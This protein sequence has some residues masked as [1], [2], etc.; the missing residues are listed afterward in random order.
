MIPRLVHALRELGPRSLSQ[1]G[2][3]NLALR[4]G[5]YRRRLPIQSW[6]QVE[7]S[8]R[9]CHDVP[10][11]PEGYTAYRVNRQS[12]SVFKLTPSDHPLLQAV[13]KA[14]EEE[15]KGILDGHFRLFGVPGIH[16]G[17]P[18]NWYAYAPLA[19]IEAGETVQM[20]DH[21][22]TYRLEQL[23]H[24]V[25]LLWEP[26]RFGWVYPLT[27][28]Y[29]LSGDHRYVEGFW[30]LYTSWLES[31]P[32]QAGL[33]WFSA[34]E[35]A[36]RL[37]AL[38]FAAYTFSDVMED[39]PQR[40]MDLLRGIVVH[41]ER[42]PVSLAYARA[43]DNNHLLVES[44]ALFLVGL[45]FPEFAKAS[46]WKR[47]GRSLFLAGMDRQVFDD[48]GYVQ[49]STNY[50]RL[51]LQLGILVAKE[52]SILG[53]PLNSSALKALADMATCLSALVDEE[54]GQTPNFGPNDGAMLLPLSNCDFEDYRPTLQA[55]SYLLEG[56][57]RYPSGQW[58]DLSLWLKLVTG[59]KGSVTTARQDPMTSQFPE[60][61][62]Y[63]TQGKR[64]K[65]M[66][67]VV[68]FRNRPGHS[69][70][71]HLD[72]WYRGVNL[73]RDP[74]SYL[75]NANP[76]WDNPFSG[77]WCHN[78]VSLDN[79]EPM[80][81]AGRFLWLGWS[82]AAILGYWGSPQERV[83]VLFA[84]YQPWRWSGN[85]HQ[86]TVARIDGEVL[87]V[88]DD[89]LGQGVHNVTLN[90]NLA[91]LAWH[92]DRNGLVLR[93]EDFSTSL[94]WLVENSSWGLYRAGECI[95]G[96]DLVENST[97][98]GWHARTYAQREPGL[99]LVVQTEGKLPLRMVSLWAFQGEG[100]DALEVSW[101][102]IGE[103]RPALERLRW[104]SVEWAV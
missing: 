1:Y 93:N 64:L 71:M 84:R 44:A 38:T 45:C 5:A 48:G 101:L 81:K 24:D 35:V 27:Q 63:L 91:D 77:A 28:A 18:P 10:S 23:P 51:V 36:I 66:F 42:I 20:Q 6:S 46:H 76:P 9:L 98:Y 13:S 50:Q 54:Y 102:P 82:R 49:H 25:K 11:D 69:D 40:W 7:L 33:H 72:I 8:G 43:Q 12:N 14:I 3:Y 75:Y 86:R 17:F 78:T 95:S 16:L 88:S 67:R 47:E 32:P 2:L 60:A 52:A 104:G 37:I 58:D 87:L 83:E 59:A 55:A 97:I 92:T 90:W 65:T 41:A 99:Q 74:G 62:L 80:L 29:S 70:Q 31:N 39:E 30:T 89:I 57:P 19:G 4:S 61:G 85:K 21:W 26:S 94:T 96:D 15:A 100:A 79:R 73:A 53:E 56:E 34:Q 22:S 103:G 68:H